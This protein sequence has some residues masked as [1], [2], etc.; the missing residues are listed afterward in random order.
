VDKEGK[1]IDFLLRAHQEEA[2]ARHYFEKTIDQNGTPETVTVDKSGANLAA[3]QVFNAE[4]EA[5]IKVRQNRYL[6]NFVEQDHRPIKP[7]I[8][9]TMGFEDFRCARIILSGIEVNA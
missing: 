8:K 2:G 3:L 9:P 4:R 6:S 7:V 5:P 1:A